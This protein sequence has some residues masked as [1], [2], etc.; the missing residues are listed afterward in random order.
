MYIPEGRHA[1]PI[2]GVGGQF[3]FGR[4]TADLPKNSLCPIDVD[5]WD[6]IF[7]GGCGTKVQTSTTFKVVD[8][9]CQ[10]LPSGAWIGAI[11][12]K[13][14]IY[15]PVIACCDDVNNLNP[16]PANDP[17]IGVTCPPG[18]H[19]TV[20][21]DGSCTCVPDVDPCAG[22]SC[23]PGT[24]PEVQQDGTCLCVASSPPPSTTAALM[25]IDP[26][27]NLLCPPS[28]HTEQQPDGTCLCVP[29]SPASTTLYAPP[30]TITDP[31]ANVSCPPGTHTEVID[32][33]CTCVSDINVNVDL[34]FGSGCPV[35]STPIEYT[36]DG[37]T[38]PAGELQ[39]GTW[40]WTKHETSGLYGY[41]QISAI[42]RLMAKCSTVVLDDG[43]IF[44]CS[45]NHRVLTPSGFKHLYELE[46]NMTLVGRPNGMVLRIEPAGDLE[47]V[48]ITVEG[49]H[50]YVTN[51]IVSHNAK[52]LGGP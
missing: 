26:C 28:Q 10:A 39:V 31:C 34:G 50:T 30:S 52:G 18:Y 17:C 11:F 43:R 44:T 45:F 49:A 41:H 15:I 20:L 14:D 42:S 51:G 16:P 3:K 27:A 9:A 7:D 23:P 32:G 24:V 29:D 8:G 21:Q 35:P 46:P 40:L 5:E 12:Y 36:I 4:L 2:P 38:M 25:Q 22:V 1:N 48:K 13:D 6:I 19:T 37:K 33:V 47:V